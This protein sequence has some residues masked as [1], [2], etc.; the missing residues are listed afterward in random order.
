MR[1]R[2]QL[3]LFVLCCVNA[4]LLL[5]QPAPAPTLEAVQAR[6]D[7]LAERG[8]PESE[9]RAVQQQLEHVLTQL[10]SAAQRRAELQALRTQLRDAPQLTAEARQESERLK[11]AP[12]ASTSDYDGMA[13]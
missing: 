1:L 7:T 4:A 6:L 12:G 3:L 2:R 5:A 10:E 9:Q 8:L 11:L 13:L